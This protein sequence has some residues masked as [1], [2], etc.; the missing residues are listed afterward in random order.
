M[1]GIVLYESRNGSTKQY[2][3]W[4]AADIGFDCAPARKARRLEDYDA[5]AIGSNVHTYKV[6]LG[7]W[8]VKKWAA[9]KGKKVAIFTVAGAP[10]QSPQRAQWLEESV[11]K[12]IASAVP[13]FPLQG[14]MKFADMRWID[15]KMIALGVM[16]TAKKDPEM[17]KKIG[18]EFDAVDRSVLKPIA[19]HFKKA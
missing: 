16:M 10:S 19:E 6:A 18:M 5:V 12:D 8:I 7:P 14:R 13:H 15:R 17:A 11:G 4:L 9:L 1:R 2:A 3:E